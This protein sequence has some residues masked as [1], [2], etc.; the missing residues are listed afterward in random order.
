ME[1]QYKD[2]DRRAVL[3]VS[4]SQRPE[5]KHPLAVYLFNEQGDLVYREEV[6][7][8]NVVL[9]L[10]KEG[11]GR[12][13]L[14]IAPIDSRIDEKGITATQLQR[15]GAYEPVL[16]YAGRLIPRIDI[17]GPL[18]DVW[19]FCFCWVRGRVFRYSDN[20]AVCN[21]RV[22]ICEVDR[23][24]L[25]ISKL[26]DPDIF[27]L[28]DDLLDALRNPPI[29]RPGPDPD[30]GP[31]QPARSTLRFTNDD[32]SRVALNP[33]PLPPREAIMLPTQ[34]HASL[35]SPS[36][37][38]VRN[39]LAENWKLLVPWL[40][41]WPDWWWRFRCDEMAVLTT[42][43]YG[44]FETTLLYLCGG[45]HPD[46]YFWVEYDFGS[47]F[48]TV[49]NP[50][51]ACNT[52][53]DYVC[54]SEVTIRITDPR[55][56]GCEGEPNLPGSQ[57]VVL[58][59]GRDV[60]V[61]QVRTSGGEGLTNVGQ[62]FGASLEPRV[63]FSRT[64]LIDVLNIPYYRWSY[65]RLTG[66][67][68]VTTTVA[69]GSLPI[70]V[71]TV[72]TRD[73]YRH[74]KV[75]TG[76]PS[77]F[78]GPMPTAGPNAAPAPNLFRI[79]PLLPPAGNEW[80]VLNENIDLATAYF[81]TDSLAGA[82]AGGP[83]L[84]EDL[85]AGL[86]ELKLELFDVT[87]A[88]VDWTASGIDLRITDQDA[89]FPAGT[90]TTSSAPDYNRI[91]DGGNT[92]GFRMIVRVDNNRCVAEILPVGGTV[93]PDSVCGFHTYSSP[94]DTA[95]L[96]FVARHPNNFAT[97]RFVTTRSS[98]PE[99][100][101]ASTTGTVGSAGA[102]SFL[103]V[104]TFTYTKNVF[105]S[106]LLGLCPNAAFSER[107]DVTAMAINGYGQLSGYNAADNAAFALAQPCPICGDGEGD[108]P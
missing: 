79:R 73:V 27:R 44:R 59:I 87:G 72:M 100:P 46:L 98:S 93:T 36:S 94:S 90:V 92:K 24:P 43:A 13:R 96:A 89:P 11:P 84:S 40:C 99:I 1:T 64:Q 95:A 2:N 101:E 54:G 70:N 6:L 76:Y 105:V 37:R 22:H 108:G 33:Q 67:D 14:F 48:E 65:R 91:L 62:P 38:L 28:R 60:A 74:Y 26:P 55:V 7:E 77:D 49:Y 61:R 35:R 56:P 71:W 34:L 106:T 57:V 97:Y 17:P 83:P 78:M 85:A 66:P 4:T 107:L 86:Y 51:I 20:R 16:E 23:I 12:A 103:R 68:G 10:P 25:W 15:L 45:D 102:N 32:L 18:I 42:D 47:G 88:L 3:E 39:V 58:S 104:D 52:Y 80:V 53:W 31:L 5:F 9:P 8:G 50:P 29:P 82:P 21:A 41:H 75:G 30:P 81:D 69:A 19:P 63:D